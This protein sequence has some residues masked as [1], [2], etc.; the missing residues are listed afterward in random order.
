MA[1]L[2]YGELAASGAGAAAMALYLDQVAATNP[3]R[4]VE[5]AVLGTAIGGLFS[6]FTQQAGIINEF[7]DGLWAGGIAWLALHSGAKL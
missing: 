5:D 1:K 3:S 4:A 7:S 6:L 2:N